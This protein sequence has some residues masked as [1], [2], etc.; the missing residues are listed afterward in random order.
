[1]ALPSP[2]GGGDRGGVGG[3]GEGRLL[4]PGWTRRGPAEPLAPGRLITFEIISSRLRFWYLA[5]AAKAVLRRRS[6]GPGQAGL[7]DL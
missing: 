6:Y 4:W 3:D 2:N 5:G 1:M 7:T